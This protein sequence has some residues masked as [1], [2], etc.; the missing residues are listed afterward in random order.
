MSAAVGVRS[1]LRCRPPVTQS[2]V[3]L[4]SHPGNPRPLSCDQVRFVT[5]GFF[6]SFQ[7]RWG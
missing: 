5:F 2:L 6:D 7:Q 4:P 1:A 3:R